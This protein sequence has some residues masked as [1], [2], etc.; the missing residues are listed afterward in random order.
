[1][2]IR[3]A[4]GVLTVSCALAGGLGIAGYAPAQ[5]AAASLMQ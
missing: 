1:L 2:Q 5:S 4:D 3:Q